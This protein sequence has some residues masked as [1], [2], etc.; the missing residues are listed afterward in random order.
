MDKQVEYKGYDF[1]N[2]DKNYKLKNEY[3]NNYGCNIYT[4]NITSDG[5]YNPVHLNKKHKN[6]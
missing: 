1:T 2:E 6:V 4:R 3:F 5:S